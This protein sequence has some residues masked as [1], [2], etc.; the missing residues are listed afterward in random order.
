[1]AESTHLTT[2]L[3]QTLLTPHPVLFALP[4]AALAIR[5][6][7]WVLPRPFYLCLTAWNLESQVWPDVWLG[8]SDSGECLGGRVSSSDYRTG[9]QQRTSRAL[10]L[11]TRPPG[12]RLLGEAAVCPSQS[13][14]NPRTLLLSS[15]RPVGLAGFFSLHLSYTQPLGAEALLE[16]K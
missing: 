7:S 10:S 6:P 8:A 15:R 2:A 4:P 11:P 5:G 14:D 1:M 9:I 13:L 16:N 12:D 3:D